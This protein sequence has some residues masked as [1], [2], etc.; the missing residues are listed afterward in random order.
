MKYC[1]QALETGMQHYE[2]GKVENKGGEPHHPPGFQQFLDCWSRLAK[3]KRER[4]RE[5]ERELS[6]LNEL[7]SWRLDFREVKEDGSCRVPE[8]LG[9]MKQKS[10]SYLHRSLLETLLSP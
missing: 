8:R 2:N 3:N 5:R 1:F 6:D 9:A 7:K 10:L 4:E